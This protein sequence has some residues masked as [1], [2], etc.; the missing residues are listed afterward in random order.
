MK[1]PRARTFS[2]R[3]GRPAGS[4]PRPRS[5]RPSLWGHLKKAVA[6]G[7]A[8]RNSYGISIT[9]NPDG[10]SSWKTGRPWW[11]VEAGEGIQ[12]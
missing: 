4:G 6:T 9:L 10:F 2:R 1:P 11:S 12:L 7:A 3:P 5:M 8:A